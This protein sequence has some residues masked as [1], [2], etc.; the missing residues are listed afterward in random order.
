MK[1]LL[2]TVKVKIDLIVA[3]AIHTLRNEKGIS[4]LELFLIFGVMA[5]LIFATAGDSSPDIEGWWTNK[6]MPNFPN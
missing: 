1:N 6:I 5:I 4:T 3:D 2:L